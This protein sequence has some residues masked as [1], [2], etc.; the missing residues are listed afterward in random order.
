MRLPLKFKPILK[1]KIWGGRRLGRMYGT[2]DPRR[3]IGEAWLVDESAVVAEGPQAGTP[4]RQMA[5]ADPAGLT[6]T[7]AAGGRLDFPLLVKLLDAEDVLSVQV[8]PDDAYA[9]A[10]EG[11]PF[12]KCEVWCVLEA[13]PGASIIHGFRRRLTRD[14]LRQAIAESRLVDEMQQ[15]EVK[16]GDVVLNTPG[17]V[18]ALGKGILIY[19]LQQSSDLTYR[20]YDWDRLS[21][22]VPRPLHIE[23]SIEVSDL[24][25]FSAHKIQPVAFHEP[26]LTRAILSACRY[27]AVELLTFHTASAACGERTDGA[28]CH[29]LTALSGRALL[30][31]GPGAAAVALRQGESALIP[32]DLGAYALQADGGACAVVK[33]WVPDLA[34]DIVRPLLAQGIPAARIAQLGGDGE[35]SDLRAVL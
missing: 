31:C 23:Q 3:Q 10:R 15:V 28:T 11:Q 22:G 30:R 17:T 2:D 33:A 32:A 35:R 18:H 6:G 29:I 26:G 13:E 20:L 21:D 34:E 19:E 9:R 1:D 4:L 27:F 24:Q 8:H 5:R 7:R 25:P 12:G 14:E 16:P